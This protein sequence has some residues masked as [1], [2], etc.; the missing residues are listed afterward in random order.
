[1]GVG[2]LFVTLDRMTRKGYLDTHVSAFD[3][4]P[5]GRAKRLYRLTPKA[6][7]ALNDVRQLSLLLRDVPDDI[8][9]EL[10]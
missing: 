8:E 3:G 4:G 6:K 2:A 9:E 1:V 7:E 10:A 5:G